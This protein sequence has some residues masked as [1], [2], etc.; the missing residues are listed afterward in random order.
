MPLSLLCDEHIP[1][2]V[3]Q[4]LRRRDIDIITVQELNL[5]SAEDEKI[6]ERAVEEERVIYTQDTDFLRLHKS[7]Y[8]HYGIIYHHQ[9]AYS[10][11]EIIRNIILI[12]QTISKQEIKGH[13][14]FL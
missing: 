7:G 10:I 8:M 5:S 6:I 12:C 11:G 3:V 4:G 1:Y 2:Q 13:V 14:R 9:Q